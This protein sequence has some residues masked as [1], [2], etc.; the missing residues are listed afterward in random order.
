MWHS[1]SSSQ[2]ALIVTLSVDDAA[3]YKDTI[4]DFTEDLGSRTVSL[5]IQ[6]ANN[7]YCDNANRWSASLKATIA[8]V[9]TSMFVTRCSP[10]ALCLLLIGIYVAV[11][12]M[13]VSADECTERADVAILIPRLAEAC[14]YRDIGNRSGSDTPSKVLPLY[15]IM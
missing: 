14:S 7:F 2:V 3:R 15:I 1:D 9:I 5:M 11:S 13:P 8:I 6:N 10:S 12:T 4:I